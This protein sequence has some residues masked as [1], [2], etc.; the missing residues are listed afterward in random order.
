[1][2]T[3]QYD[4]LLSV[5]YGLYLIGGK[6][7]LSEGGDIYMSTI[8]LC[9]LLLTYSLTVVISNPKTFDMEGLE[10]LQAVQRNKRRLMY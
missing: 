5:N 6:K 3:R 1:M 2:S 4:N 10:V 8:R 9:L 7:I